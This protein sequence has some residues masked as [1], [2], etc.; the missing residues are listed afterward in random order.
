MLCFGKTHF[1]CFSTKK[2]V[3]TKPKRCLPTAHT[4]KNTH[5]MGPFLHL[6]KM[7]I[8]DQMLFNIFSNN[9]YYV[10][11]GNIMPE[12]RITHTHTHT[13]TN[14]QP[15]VRTHHSTC[16]RINIYACRVGGFGSHGNIPL[17]PFANM[18]VCF[19]LLALASIPMPKSTPNPSAGGFRNGS[20]ASKEGERWCI[21]SLRYKLCFESFL[22]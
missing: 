19:S 13:H 2:H 4:H 10:V 9:I 21:F 7:Y 16:G 1:L 15:H 6:I 18:P 5:T 12:W 17:T 3:L 20:V 11:L 8:H 14:T 22:D